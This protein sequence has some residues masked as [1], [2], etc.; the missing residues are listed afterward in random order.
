MKFL[1]LLGRVQSMYAA[2]GGAFCVLVCKRGGLAFAHVNA[3]PRVV[4]MVEK[5]IA[6]PMRCRGC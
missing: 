4:S 3:R 1:G 2:M 5:F 6:M